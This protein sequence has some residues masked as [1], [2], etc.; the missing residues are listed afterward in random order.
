MYQG[1]KKLSEENKESVD[2]LSAAVQVGLH[3][4][5]GI[6]IHV[7]KLDGEE[8]KARLSIQ[9]AWQVAGAL[10]ANTSVIVASMYAQ[11]AQE[12]ALAK[13]LT[14]KIIVP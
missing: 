10:T 1:V 14:N 11:A 13:Q 3:P 5:G 7:K 4:L 8:V 2:E 9:E 12:A 6:A